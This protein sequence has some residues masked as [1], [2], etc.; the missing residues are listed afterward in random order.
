M[1]RRAASIRAA[2]HQVLALLQLIRLRLS[3]L[4]STR[5]WAEKTESGRASGKVSAAGTGV[6]RSGSA[7]QTRVG[8]SSDSSSSVP[9]AQDKVRFVTAT[10]HV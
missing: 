8:S 10:L 4:R 3:C 6:M 1:Q 5:T 7:A 2:V 9:L